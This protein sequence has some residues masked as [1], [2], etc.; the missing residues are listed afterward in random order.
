MGNLFLSS[1]NRAL[2]LQGM[3]FLIRSSMIC[4]KKRQQKVVINKII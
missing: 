2:F 4:D 1:Y 3:R